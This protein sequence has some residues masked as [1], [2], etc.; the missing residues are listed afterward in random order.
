MSDD[1]R[2][3]TQAPVILHDGDLGARRYA[4]WLAEDFETTASYVTEADPAELVVAGTVVVFTEF[5]PDGELGATEF[6]QENWEA[7]VES[8]RRVAIGMVGIQPIADDSR[9][10]AMS[11][12]FSGDQLSKIKLF[13]FRGAVDESTLGFREK[14]ALKTMAATIRRKQ[15]RTPDEQALVDN[16]KGLDFT[17]RATLGPM[18]RWIRGEA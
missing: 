14:L 17:D 4:G 13:Q 5:R 6:V 2:P 9:I 10:N 11:N 12:A 16:G 15:R 8:G 18:L 1:S 7:I 3:A